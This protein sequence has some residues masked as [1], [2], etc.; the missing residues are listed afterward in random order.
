MIESVVGAGDDGE[1]LEISNAA[2]CALDL[3][4]LHGDA[5][6]G[7]KVHTFDIGV[8]AW[9]PAGGSFLVADSADPSINPE[10]PGMLFTWSGTG[11]DILRN[12]GGTV[13]L[14]VGETLV[15]SV[16]W[17]K[18]KLIAGTSVELPASCSPDQATD[19]TVWQDAQSSWFPAFFGTPNA[20]NDD[21]VCPP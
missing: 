21:V 10:L 9:V 14:T 11:G 4:G 12:E 8:D 20:P 13:T 6:V 2:D 18:L 19:F 17:P 1:W 16:T 3:R 5:P 7:A 15:T